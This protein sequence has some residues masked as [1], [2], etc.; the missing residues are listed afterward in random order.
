MP[1]T[2]DYDLYWNTLEDMRRPMLEPKEARQLALREWT[3]PLTRSYNGYTGVERVRGWQFAWWLKQVGVLSWPAACDV[4]GASKASY[5][6]EDYYNVFS[7]PALCRACHRRVH[8]RFSDPR[9]WAEFV[10]VS[11]SRHDR[12]PPDAR[13]WFALLPCAEI[14]LAGYVRKRFGPNVQ[15]LLNSPLYELPIAQLY[16]PSGKFLGDSLAPAF[17]RPAGGP[18]H[19][20]L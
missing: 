4:C 14:D 18:F 2:F 13:P 17:S 15:D 16:P 3:W 12:F 8:T 7:D 5:H 6:S 19:V 11:L 20:S 9:G 1:L 10:D